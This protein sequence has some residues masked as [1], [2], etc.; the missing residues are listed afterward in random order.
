MLIGIDPL[1]SPDLLHAL[2]SMG[3]RQDIAIV[4]AN[5]PCEPGARVIRLDGISATAALEAVLSVLPLEVEEP[6]SAWRMIAHDDPEE[7]LPV[8]AD[9]A[10][11]VDR[12]SP[13]TPLTAI[14]PGDFKAQASAAYAILVTGERRL[15]GGIIVRKG[16][17]PPSVG[18]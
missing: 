11:I 6:A 7:I 14:D 3:H 5:F 9:F 12:H 10:E 17:V 4:D 8:F 16:V 1:L 15:Y 18:A 2:R 13:G